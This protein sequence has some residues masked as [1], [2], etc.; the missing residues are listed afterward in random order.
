MDEDDLE[1]D[2]VNTDDDDLIR[3]GIIVLSWG[4][5]NRCLKLEM[6]TQSHGM[7]LCLG[8]DTSYVFPV[9]SISHLCTFIHTQTCIST[10][11]D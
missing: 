5:K 8:S 11:Q 9:G 3:Y 6:M 10:T 1:N 7:G 2:A 4:V